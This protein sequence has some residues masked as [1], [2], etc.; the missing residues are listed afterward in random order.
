MLVLV[1]INVEQDEA[2]RA[3]VYAADIVIS[4]LPPFLHYLVAKDC[5]QYGKNLLTASYV[6]EKI[7]TLRDEIAAKGLFFL[8]EMGLDP[9]IDHMSAMQLITNIREKGG[10]ITSFRSHCGGLVAP[11]SDD[12]PWHYKISW[13]PRNVVMAGKAGAVYK[14]NNQKVEIAYADSIPCR[15]YSAGARPRRTCLVCQQGFTLSYIPVYGL[16][17]SRTFLRTTLRYP[18]FNAGWQQIVWLRLTDEN[19]IYNTD[20]PFALRLLPRTFQEL[21]YFSYHR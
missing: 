1:A 12:N 15:Q 9:G 6:D 5:V 7:T 8:C 10:A 19:A 11:E 21:R 3:L 17:A 2:R 18:A 13:N 14:D 16:D 4:L 20:G